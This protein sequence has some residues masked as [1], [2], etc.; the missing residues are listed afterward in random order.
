MSV[1]N[2]FDLFRKEPF[3]PEKYQD[4]LQEYYP[5]EK[6]E[7]NNCNLAI[8]ALTDTFTGVIVQVGRLNG[9]YHCWAKAPDG[10]ILDPTKPPGIKENNYDLIAERFLDKDE[11]EVATGA[12]FL[13]NTEPENESY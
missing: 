6:W 1:Q 3:T 13:K 2:A 9:V 10:T 7:P 11:I 4:W 5:L 12:L 8:R